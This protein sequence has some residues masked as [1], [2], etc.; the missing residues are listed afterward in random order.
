MARKQPQRQAARLSPAE[1][2]KPGRFKMPDI[3]ARLDRIF[4]NRA[5]SAKQ[6]AAMRAAE[7][8]GEE[9]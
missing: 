3:L 9:G 4:G 7:L 8:E 6:V 5:Y 1:P 2:E